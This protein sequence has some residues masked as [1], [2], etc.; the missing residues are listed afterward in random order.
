LAEAGGKT[1]AEL[2]KNEAGDVALLTP[3]I[4]GQVGDWLRTAA[5]LDVGPAELAA[6]V[7]MTSW[8]GA[9]YIGVL[10]IVLGVTHVRCRLQTF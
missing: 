9:P 8:V 1:K 5:R 4:M 10:C 2:A 7:A 6:A 3:S